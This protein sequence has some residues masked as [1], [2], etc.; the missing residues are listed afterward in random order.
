MSNYVLRMIRREDRRHRQARCTIGRGTF[1][2]VTT[3]AT[4][5]PCKVRPSMTASDNQVMSGG[6]QV[7]LVRYEVG[8]AFDQDIRRNDVITV[9]VSADPLLVGRFLSVVEVTVD[10]WVASRIVICEESR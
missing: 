3:V 7:G 5:V 2:D 9:D 8:L 10:E 6:Q 1:P 4:Q